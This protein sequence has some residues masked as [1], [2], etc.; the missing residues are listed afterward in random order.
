MA[1]VSPTIGGRHPFFSFSGS[2]CSTNKRFFFL[3]IIL[4]EITHTRL[5]M[6]M[7]DYRSEYKIYNMAQ[8]TTYQLYEFIKFLKVSRLFFTFQLCSLSDSI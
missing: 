3:I 7:I 1:V 5:L 8:L 2:S 6:R 4:F